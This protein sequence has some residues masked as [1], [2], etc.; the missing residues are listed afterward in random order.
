MSSSRPV[1]VITGAS[2]G[3]GAIFARALRRARARPHPRRPPGRAPHQPRGSPHKPTRHRRRVPRTGPH[4]PDVPPKD[5]GICLRPRLADRRVGQQR[6]VWRYRAVPRARHRQESRSDPVERGSAHPPHCTRHAPAW[7]SGAR[8]WSST[9]ASTAAFQPGPGMAVYCAT[10]AYVLS[11]SE[12]ISHE[13]APHGVQVT[14]HCP[15]ATATEFSSIAR[16]DRTRLFQSGKSASA[17]DVVDD[18]LRAMDQGSVVR[19]HGKLNF[20]LAQSN[21]FAPRALVRSAAARFLLTD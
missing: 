18:A 17:E 15:G 6:R 20:L 11:F 7:W 19:I 16:N 21:R 2:A 12:A 10:K 5:L 9:S 8:A 13:L 4:G 1:A 3:L 14:A